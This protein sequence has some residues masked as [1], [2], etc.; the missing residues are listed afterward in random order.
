MTHLR[1]QI[2]DNVT[3][4]LTGL[5][6]TGS[7]VYQSRVHPNEA[8]KLP[9]LNIYTLSESEERITMG[10]NPKYQRELEL[11]V[12]GYAKATSN[13]DNTLD[14]IALEVEEALATDLSRGGL[15]HDTMLEDT[16]VELVG[17]GEQPI[18]MVKLTYNIRYVTTAG[19]VETSG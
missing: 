18:G 4:T 19:D 15:A 7:N 1:K 3:T 5:T 11:V 14:A 16:E 9:C 12:E 6:T 8:A 10:P 13:L 17:E 2:R